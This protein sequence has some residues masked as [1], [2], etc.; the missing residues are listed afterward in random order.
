M[1]ALK[2]GAYDR[3]LEGDGRWSAAIPDERVAPSEHVDRRHLL[4]VRA[5]HIAEELAY[6]AA[7]C[8]ARLL[9][10]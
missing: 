2:E 4:R 1:Q 8:A 3:E 5:A 6:Y 10:V 7:V 9:R